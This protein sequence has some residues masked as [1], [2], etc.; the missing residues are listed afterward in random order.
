MTD[1]TF[2]PP[3]ELNIQGE[4]VQFHSAQ[5]MAFSMD[6]RTVVSSNKLGDLFKL[7]TEQLEA[8]RQ[9]IEKTR[10][11]LLSILSRVA[12]EPNI[13]N[14]L[15][16]ELDPMVFSQDR[17]WRQIVLAMNEINEGYDE[18]RTLILTKYVKYLY[19]L[20]DTVADICADRKRTLGEEVD[21][22]E[23]VTN[24]PGQPPAKANTDYE[25]EQEY[26]QLPA[27]RE[28]TIT[29]ASGDTMDVLLASHKC[30][31][32]IMGGSVQFISE[33]Q[34]TDLNP[35]LNIIGRGPNSTVK[36]DGTHK[37]VSRSHLQVFVGDDLSLI[38]TDLSST[39]TF[40]SSRCLV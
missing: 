3:L 22:E 8:Q 34:A 31:I 35:G 16:R 37:N 33:G 30:H 14:E 28:V 27:D 12:K 21:E 25:I 1:A 11:A 23:D 4:I 40:V 20:E 10:T 18:A 24:L 36:I 13:V 26:V 15:M 5:E 6:G 19:A 38:F 9:S 2:I 39:G 17:S 32:A 7:N 29:L